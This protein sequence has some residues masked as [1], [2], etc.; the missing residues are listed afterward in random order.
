MPPPIDIPIFY[1]QFLTKPVVKDMDKV[2]LL[3]PHSHTFIWNK[4]FG[5]TN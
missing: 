3:T 2:F 5:Y 4:W 1:E